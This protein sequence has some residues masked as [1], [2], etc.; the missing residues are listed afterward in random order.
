[1]GGKEGNL[2]VYDH[3]CVYI[4]YETPKVVAL[5]YRCWSRLEIGVASTMSR[6]VLHMFAFVILCGGPPAEGQG[7]YLLKHRGFS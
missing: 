2:G 6:L 4:R 3:G 5:A 7:I 1:M